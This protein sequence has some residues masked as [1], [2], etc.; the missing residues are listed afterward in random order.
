[1]NIAEI[2]AA[3]LRC[4]GYDG[5]CD[6]E[7]GCFVADLMPCDGPQ[8]TCTAGYA[9]KATQED[10]DNGFEGAVGARIIKEERP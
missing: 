3:W 10:V 6:E 1:M 2:T 7:C 4:H 9:H 8:L 5:L